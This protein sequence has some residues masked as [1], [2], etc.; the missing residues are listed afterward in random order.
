MKKYFENMNNC[1]AKIEQVL[2][3]NMVTLLFIRNYKKSFQRKT[4]LKKRV[5]CLLHR[6]YY[7]III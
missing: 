7:Y 2:L 6:V 3:D 5:C 4:F 1:T